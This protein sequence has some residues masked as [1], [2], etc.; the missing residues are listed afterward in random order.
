MIP[1]ISIIITFSLKLISIKV[2]V[3]VKGADSKK[4]E[5]RSWQEFILASLFTSKCYSKNLV[6]QICQVFSNIFDIFTKRINENIVHVCS[7][8]LL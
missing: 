1:S 6:S 5:S 3:I 4:L 7:Y 8:I 2:H